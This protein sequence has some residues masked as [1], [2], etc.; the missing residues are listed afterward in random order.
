M[1]R[2]SEDVMKEDPGIKNATFEVAIIFLCE[3]E[4]QKTDMVAVLNFR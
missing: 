3:S 2:L 4:H 1:V